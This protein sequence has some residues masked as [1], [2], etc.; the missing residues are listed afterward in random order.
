MNFCRN[1]SQTKEKFCPRCKLYF[2]S[3]CTLC[4]HAEIKPIPKFIIS[5]YVL[6]KILGNVCSFKAMDPKNEKN[7]YAIYVLEN[8][9]A[10]SQEEFIN[11]INRIN[12]SDNENILKIHDYHIDEG[13]NC[14]IIVTDFADKNMKNLAFSLDEN[15]AVEVMVKLCETIHFLHKEMKFSHGKIRLKNILLQKNIVKITNYWYKEQK[16]QR[17]FGPPEILRNPEK[18][19]NKNS[20]IWSLG[21]IFHKLLAKN[22]NP[23]LNYNYDGVDSKAKIRQNILDD[24]IFMSPCIKNAKL[25]KIIKG[26]LFFFTILTQFFKNVSPLR[27]NVF[28]FQKLLKF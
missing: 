12:L 18:T 23:F 7:I 5:N 20:D 3:C 24:R 22:A 21:V 16:K 4:S 17:M 9:N 10:E 15:K 14:L 27:W 19:S 1:H 2:C 26:I 13:L 25:C 6:I 8:F 28:L 11:I